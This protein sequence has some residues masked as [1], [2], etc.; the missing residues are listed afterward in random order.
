MPNI[1]KQ[2][3]VDPKHGT[4]VYTTYQYKKDKPNPRP[5]E[6]KSRDVGKKA[7]IKARFGLT[8]ASLAERLGIEDLDLLAALA[9]GKTGK[10]IGR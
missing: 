1:T 5:G 4:P 2:T 3:G 9:R 7:Q 8:I 10:R 6:R